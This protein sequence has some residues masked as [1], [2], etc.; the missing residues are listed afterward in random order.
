MKDKLFICK[1]CGK[2]T[3]NKYILKMPF[4]NDVVIHRCDACQDKLDAKHEWKNEKWREDNII[5]PWCEEEG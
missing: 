4:S 5:C 2:P 3:N 1:D